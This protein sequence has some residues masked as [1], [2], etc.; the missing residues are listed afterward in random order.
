MHRTILLSIKF[1]K[2]FSISSV[3]LAFGGTS[4]DTGVGNLVYK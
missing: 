4:I 3:I 1:E 2:K